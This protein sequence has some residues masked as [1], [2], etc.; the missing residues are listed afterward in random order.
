MALANIVHQSPAQKPNEVGVQDVQPEVAMPTGILKENE[1]ASEFKSP[2]VTPTYVCVSEQSQYSDNTSQDLAATASWNSMVPPLGLVSQNAPP[3][4]LSKVSVE[5]APATP[6]NSTESLGYSGSYV[7]SSECRFNTGEL[8]SMQWLNQLLTYGTADRKRVLRSCSSPPSP[9]PPTTGAS[10]ETLFNTP[11]HSNTSSPFSLAKFRQVLDEHTGPK[12]VCHNALAEYLKGEEAEQDQTEWVSLVE[13]IK[14]SNQSE[15]IKLQKDH[16]TTV[17]KLRQERSKE[18]RGL[19]LRNREVR[20]L[21]R[22]MK[23]LKKSIEE[24][25]KEK[26]QIQPTPNSDSAD[27]SDAESVDEEEGGVALATKNSA[28]TNNVESAR[29]DTGDAVQEVEVVYHGMRIEN[30]GMSQVKTSKKEATEEKKKLQQALKQQLMED[31]IPEALLQVEADHPAAIGDPQVESSS[32]NAAASKGNNKTSFTDLEDLQTHNKALQNNLAFTREVIH[33]MQTEAESRE[34]ELQELQQQNHSAQ[35]EFARLHAA[36]AQYRSILEDTDHN[37]ARTAHLDG[38]LKRKDEAITHLESH[39]AEVLEHLDAEKHARATDNAYFDSQNQG[40]KNELAHRLNT[41]A[42]LIAGRDILRRHNDGVHNM[43]RGRITTSDAVAAFNR[44]HD[45][46]VSDH[47]L[48][49][50]IANE[51]RCYVLDAEN[52]V[53]KLKAEILAV[54]LAQQ[55]EV[56]EHRDTQRRCNGLVAVNGE[57]EARLEIRA[58]IRDEEVVALEE[59]VRVLETARG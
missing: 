55:K 5:P 13:W 49:S 35:L 38:L 59:K 16:A 1:L 30:E 23:E 19:E 24:T 22:E 43:L 7:S 32:Q 4:A 8:C 37:P 33:T 14:I 44:D 27:D 26:E 57:L 2:D 50:Q 31:S 29:E 41:I 25:T 34:S 52:A 58:E 56:R 53:G 17:E 48:L 40:L 46:L 18:R 12:R 54:E 21:K 3:V 15:V 9:S 20:A 42:A 45:A 39:A 47:A 6:Q 51:R 10:S 11:R 28:P 36:N